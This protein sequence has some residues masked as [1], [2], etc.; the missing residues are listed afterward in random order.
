M[1]E[2]IVHLPEQ[3]TTSEFAEDALTYLNSDIKS[4]A[5][6]HKTLNSWYRSI[7]RQYAAV[8]KREKDRW[9]ADKTVTTNNGPVTVEKLSLWMSDNSDILEDTNTGVEVVVPIGNE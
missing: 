6:K 3:Y 1:V 8:A 9:V 7:L 2:L 4:K 5:D